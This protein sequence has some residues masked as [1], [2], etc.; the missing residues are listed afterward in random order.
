MVMA[1]AS[2]EE[3]VQ[4]LEKEVAELKQAR[5]GGQSSDWRG[6]IGMF[7]HDPVMKRI[8]D[9]ALEYREKD[10]KAAKK[11]HKGNGRKRA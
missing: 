9:N 1:Q 4:A 11:K 8:F 3:R 2:L 7:A 5:A 10:R 6:T